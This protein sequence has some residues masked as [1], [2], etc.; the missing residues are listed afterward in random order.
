MQLPYKQIRIGNI[1][2]SEI[3][4]KDLIK[5]WV[6][7]SVAFGILIAGSF[8]SERFILSFLIS[9]FTV[10]TGFIVHELAHKFIAQRYGCFAEFRAF[11]TMLMLAIIMSFFGFILAA[12]GAVM[13]SG[14]VGIRRN[15]KIS[16]AGPASN[17][18]LAIIFLGLLF[19]GPSGLLL[20]IASYGFLINTWLGIFNLIPVWNFD[21]K[22]ILRWN[23]IVYGAMVAVGLFL[24]FM[25]SFINI[26]I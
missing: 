10:G 17:F 13:I 19:T 26:S 18:A 3:E 6:A 21:G 22:K 5:A 23:K 25:Q 7:I 12:P 1:A 2:T 4:I 24:I 15:G 8:F 16:L 9:L 11:N 14:P 20:L